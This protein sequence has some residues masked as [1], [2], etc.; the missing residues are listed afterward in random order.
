M[1]FSSANLE[2]AFEKKSF[3]KAHVLC[4]LLR[5]HLKNLYYLQYCM[6]INP[7]TDDQESWV[8]DVQTNL[9]H[10]GL[11]PSVLLLCLRHIKDDKI[12][13]SAE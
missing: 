1:P 9:P 10:L 2:K 13:A 11:I 6:Q 4:K 8:L 7:E 5:C 3:W 12:F